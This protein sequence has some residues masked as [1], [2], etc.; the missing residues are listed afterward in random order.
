VREHRP[1][2]H[3]DER[4]GCEYADQLRLGH[5]GNQI[6]PIDVLEALMFA[7]HQLAIIEL[8]RIGIAGLG[9]GM[10]RGASGK[11]SE[12]R[13]QIRRTNVAN[14]SYWACHNCRARWP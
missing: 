11:I 2:D 4:G 12:D 5:V 7:A 13:M 9:D 1:I 14:V 3:G 10:D 8:D 6:G